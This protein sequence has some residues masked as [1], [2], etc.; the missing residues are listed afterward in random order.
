MLHLLVV[1]S[2]TRASGSFTTGAAAA[3]RP[4]EGRGALR[5]R[6]GR[7]RTARPNGI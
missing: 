4:A 2:F 6:P 1:D 3:P 7:S 5:T